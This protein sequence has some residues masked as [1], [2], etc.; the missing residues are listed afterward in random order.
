[1]ASV[2][3]T[4]PV[5]FNVNSPSSPLTP[6]QITL[7]AIAGGVKATITVLDQRVGDIAGVFFDVTGNT[8][9]AG[10]NVAGTDVSNKIFSINNVIGVSSSTGNVTMSG[11]TDQK[12][13]AG[14]AI[15]KSG[16]GSIYSTSFIIQNATI[17]DLLGTDPSGST[18]RWGVRLNGASGGS[19]LLG[20]V[21][22]PTTIGDR[23]FLDSDAD[24]IQDTGEAGAANVTVQLLNSSNAIVATT[25]TNSS[26]NY[27]F[28]VAPAGTYR[29]KFVAPNGY[30]FSAKGQ[31]TDGTND[32]DADPATGQTAAIAFTAGQSN[33]TLDA[34]L[35]LQAITIGDRVFVDSNGNGVQEVSEP[36]LSNV[37]VKLLNSSGGLVAST[38]TN[39][40][41]LYSFSAA[42]GTYKLQFDKPDSS[43]FFSPANVGNDATDSDVAD[44][45]TG[46][47]AA[48]TL[49]AGQQPDFN[50]D[51]GLFKKVT[52]GDRIFV[53]IDKDGIQDAS[54]TGLSNVIVNLLDGTTSA[55]VATTTTSAT[56][57]YSFTVNPGTYKVQVA[58]P[59]GYSFSPKDQGSD[60]A[61]DSDIDPVTGLT[62]NIT[63]TSGQVKADVDG[64]VFYSLSAT[65]NVDFTSSSYLTSGIF[66]EAGSGLNFLNTAAFEPSP[67]AGFLQK[68]N[69]TNNGLTAIPA[70]TVIAVKGTH[71]FVKLVRVGNTT[72]Y[73]TVGDTRTFLVT[74]PAINAGQTITLDAE[75]KVVTDSSQINTPINYQPSEFSFVLQDGTASNDYGQA[76]A[77]GTFYF[78]D[79]GFERPDSQSGA[80][81]PTSFRFNPFA[82]TNLQIDFNQNNVIDP[83]DASQDVAVLRGGGTLVEGNGT[84][85]RLYFPDIAGDADPLVRS[86]STTIRSTPAPVGVSLLWNP[87]LNLTD[88]VNS[89]DANSFTEFMELVDQGL[90]SRTN[91]TNVLQKD[92]DTLEGKFIKYNADG[93]I[94]FQQTALAGN[95]IDADSIA[96][97]TFSGGSFQSFVNALAVSGGPYRIVFQAGTST[98]IDFSRYAG[99][100]QIVEIVLPAGQTN[101]TIN[102][103]VDQ[104]QLN[105]SSIQVSTSTGRLATVSI[106]GDGGRNVQVDRITGTLGNDTINGFNGSDILNGYVGD[107]VIY[108]GASADLING[109][110]GNDSLYG[111]DGQDTFVFEKRFGNDKIFDFSKDKIDLKAFRLTSTQLS[112]ALSGN[113]INLTNFDGGLITV[114]NNGVNV[115]V[116][117]L[118]SNTFILA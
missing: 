30:T 11:A 52:I 106:T 3:V 22:L 76:V 32:S 9:P 36:S 49:T 81:S 70:G 118:S 63:L 103:R 74:L 2:I 13:D 87:V 109:G 1:M 72:Q 64:G 80:N 24:G 50:F 54:E 7:E 45:S 19:K 112:S 61:K 84:V 8:F 93:S 59:A 65:I 4:A 114:T 12:F 27:R 96:T 108:G 95:I 29:V 98:T 92:G 79:L 42:P 83:N 47:T 91:A 37:T 57:A 102:N 67:N 110:L 101:L 33:L 78:T 115:D 46:Q 55:V 107:D 97:V 82:S 104:D 100:P 26:G 85:H 10:I 60:D 43:Y 117:S 31:G 48:F 35:V 111:G 17:A 44:P 34:G 73:T 51:A 116:R 28:T 68:L 75:S 23:V 18:V 21:P 94:A 113:T 25:T 88:F 71:P 105:L 41:G 62:T 58:T 14:V 89:T 16:G 5:T 38:T 69:V 77:E 53:D 40:S 39:A 86:R 99:S 56:G 20:A 15:E 66:S 90:F 6:V